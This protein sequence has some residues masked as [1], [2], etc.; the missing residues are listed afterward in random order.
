MAKSKLLMTS[1]L[2]LLLCGCDYKATPKTEYKDIIVNKEIRSELNNVASWFFETP[3]SKNVYYFTL[4]K[5]GD[6]EVDKTS[7]DKYKIGDTYSWEE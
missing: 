7:Y 4:E 3:M 6:K 1:L 2:A 5:Y